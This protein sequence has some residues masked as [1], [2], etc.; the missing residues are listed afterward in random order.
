LFAILRVRIGG[1]HGHELASGIGK[2]L[3]GSAVMG[4]VVWATSRGME[5]WL[6]VS[7]LARLADLAVSLPIGLAAFY[8][9]CRVLKVEELEMAIRAFL[10]PL[11]RRLGRGGKITG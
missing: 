2:V 6:G 3:I 9:M 4:A 1:I 5:N 10:S 7:Q 11:R 8:G